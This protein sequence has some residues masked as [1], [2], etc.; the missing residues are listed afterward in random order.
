MSLTDKVRE[1]AANKEHAPGTG[2]KPVSSTAAKTAVAAAKHAAAKAA[3]AGKDGIKVSG[4]IVAHA[5]NKAEAAAAKGKSEA[6]HMAEVKEEAQHGS[7]TEAIKK[8]H[9]K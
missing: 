7:L 6:E 2:A 8:L 4:D 1:A 9:E 3:A 5:A